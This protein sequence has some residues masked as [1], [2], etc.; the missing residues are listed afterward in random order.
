MKVIHEDGLRTRVP[1]FH[2]V[3]QGGTGALMR[4]LAEELLGGDDG[5]LPFGLAI[6]QLPGDL[7]GVGVVSGEIDLVGVSDPAGLPA[8]VR[9]GELRRR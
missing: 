9:E 8:L 7:P 1:P 6:A 2:F 4:D 5:A 3:K